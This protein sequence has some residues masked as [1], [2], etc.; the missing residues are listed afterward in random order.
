MAAPPGP[1]R[2]R[3]LILL[4]RSVPKTIDFFGPNGLGLRILGASESYAELEAAENLVL[5]VKEVTR[6]ADLCKGYS[7]FLCFDVPD[8]DMMVPGLIM[9]GATLDGGVKHEPEGKFAV[10][11]SPDGVSIGIREILFT[12]AQLEM[13]RDAD[14]T[15]KRNGISRNVIKST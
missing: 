1:P 8:V 11:R 10:L 9:K 12:P 3:Q 2:L 14:S 6:E 15:L 7:P 13:M 4:V 5:A